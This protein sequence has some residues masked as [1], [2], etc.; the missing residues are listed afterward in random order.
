MSWPATA[1]L[2]LAERGGVLT[3]LSCATTDPSIYAVGEVAAIE[4]RCYGLVGPGYTS[5]EVVA[6]RLL[7]GAAEFPEADMSTK[8][9]LLG[10]DV[11]SFGDAMGLTPDCLEVVVNDAV[12]Q[13]YAKLVLSDD[14]KTLLGGILVG[15][16]SAY[17]ILRP[18][19]GEP[20]PGDPLAL[21]APAGSDGGSEGLGVGTLPAG[22]QICSCNNVTKG[23]LSEAIAGGC[24]DVP[25]LKQCTQAGT[26]CGSCVPLLKQLL[27]ARGRR[28]VQGAVRT[29]Q[30]VA[31]RI[32]RDHLGD[33][34]QNVLGTHRTLRDR[35]GLR[36]M[37][38]RGGIDP[39]LDELRPHSRR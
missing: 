16:A 3:D 21:I 13:T 10:V 31:R 9:K 22:A 26:S 30:P 28:A 34:D 24:C 36:H 4:G 37:Q 7:G 15:D 32:V 35:K 25:C 29:L 27:E 17:G 19:V 14:A 12:N 18:M 8:L 39:C 5:A 33:V 38:T 1:G 11:A 20:L 6:D 23:D 2:E